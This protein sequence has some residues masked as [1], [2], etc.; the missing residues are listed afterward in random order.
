MRNNRFFNL[1]LAACMALCC[2]TLFFGC[3]T[4]SPQTPSPVERTLIHEPE[5]GGIYIT[6]TID[7]FNALGFEY[8]DSVDVVFSNGYEAKD[9][10]YYNGYYVQTGEPLLVAYPGYDYIKACINNGADLWEV[11][12]VSENDTATVTLAERGKYLDI[13]QARDLSYRDEREEFPSDEVFANF[14]AIRV[15][16]LKENIVYRSA[17]PC[18]NQHCRASYTDALMQQAGVRYIINLADN[19]E[20][21]AGYLE[22][23][24]FA[25]PYFVTLYETGNVLP[26]AMNMNLTSDSFREKV[27]RGMTA[28]ARN[29][30]PF[31]VH[32]TEGKDRTG[33]FC[34]LLE[35]FAGADYDEIVRDYMITYENYYGITQEKEPA[36]WA[37]IVKDVLDP[38][39]AGM[40]GD[41]GA[42]LR[43]ADLAAGAEAFLRSAG[44]TEED[45]TLLGE[46]LKQS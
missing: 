18:D 23:E 44:M 12:G 38:M 22:R 17:S 43:E 34:M 40:L 30:G 31:L 4:G 45:L 36:K 46:R 35:A 42:D 25:S 39:I 37:I 20:K 29:D 28:I 13:Q 33:F 16:G 14:R 24:D 7:D 32:C 19:E 41:S 5:F 3:G 9:L 2:V 10:P 11:A 15:S 26:L 21:I 27:V 8:G 1:F 6:A